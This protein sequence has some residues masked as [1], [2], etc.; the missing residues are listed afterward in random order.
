LTSLFGNAFLPVRQ[1]ARDFGLAFASAMIVHLWLVIWLCVIGALPSA[2]IFV[3][4]GLAAIFTYL[5]ALLSVRRVRELLPHKFWPPILA[6]TT[7]YIVLAIV[8]DFKRFRVSD[9]RDGVAYPPFS[10]LAV[11]GLIL[12]PRRMGADFGTYV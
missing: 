11:G 3:I 5:L 8:D 7:N 4:F 9:L 10:T 2:R 6:V 1:H 12:E